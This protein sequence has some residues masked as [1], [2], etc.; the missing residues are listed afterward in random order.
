MKVVLCTR[1]VVSPIISC[2]M[3]QRTEMR[4]I[5]IGLDMHCSVIVLLTS[6]KVEVVNKVEL[7]LNFQVYLGS[8]VSNTGCIQ[9]CLIIFS[10]PI[11]L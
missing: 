2:D 9:G 5:Y 1:V 4:H 10:N 3:I 6:L 7:L 11:L 8:L